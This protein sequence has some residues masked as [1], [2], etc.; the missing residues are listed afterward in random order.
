MEE[1]KKFQ[2]KSLNGDDYKG[3]EQGA[4]AVKGVIGSLA[5]HIL[6]VY[7]AEALFTERSMNGEREKTR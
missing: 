5:Y 1:Q 7:R 2:K 4:K 6:L 3:T